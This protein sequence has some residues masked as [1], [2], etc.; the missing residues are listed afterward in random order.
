MLL[1]LPRCWSTPHFYTS[2][3]IQG[4][5][6][7]HKRRNVQAVW[8]SPGQGQ[9]QAALPAMQPLHDVC[10]KGDP[11]KVNGL[12]GGIKDRPW[13][14]CLLEDIFECRAHLENEFSINGLQPAI[15]MVAPVQT[16][17]P[18]LCRARRQCHA[19]P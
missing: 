8:G 10:L 6:R 12:F 16:C 7:I 15:A 19:V 1:V 3:L 11:C 2:T 9:G 4:K 13:A 5:L 14:S 18:F 17:S